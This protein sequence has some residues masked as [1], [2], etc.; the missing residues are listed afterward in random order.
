[1]APMRS[2]PRSTACSAPRA[3]RSAS[4]RPCR[5]RG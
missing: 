2:S 3:R 5:R 1:M 4:P